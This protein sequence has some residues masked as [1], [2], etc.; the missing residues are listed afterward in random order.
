VSVNV[1]IVA[2]AGLAFVFVGG[3]GFAV[4]HSVRETVALG[5]QVVLVVFVIGCFKTST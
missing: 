5:G 1:P 3:L 2:F 4:E